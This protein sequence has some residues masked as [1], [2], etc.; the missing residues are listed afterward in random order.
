MND[1]SGRVCV[2]TGAAS[3]IGR[4]TV[5]VCRDQ[6]ATVIGLDLAGGSDSIVC[7]DVT[8]EDAVESAFSTVASCYGGVDALIA[9]AGAQHQAIATETSLKDW[10]RMIDVNLT[11]VF[12]CAKHA[13]PRFRTGGSIVAIASVSGLVATDGEAA[14]C[15]SKAG[16]I[17]LVRALAVDYANEGIRANA[18]CPGVID[19]PMND[20]LWRERGA[21]FRNEVAELHPVGRLG[22]PREV[23]EVAAFLASPRSSFVTGATW[24]VDGGFSAV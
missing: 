19:T 13:I 16:V 8:S 7:C 12:L 2:V 9:C 21:E 5:E 6:G 24:T 10:Q 15:S 3:G 4:T 1:L 17:G 22:S 23:A 20:V 14:Y 18:I 11:G